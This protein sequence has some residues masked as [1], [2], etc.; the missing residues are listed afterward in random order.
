MRA[1]GVAMVKVK[2]A[3]EEPAARDGYRVL[4]DRL[5]PRGVKK[6][7]LALDDWAKELA[8]S[9]ALRTWFAHDEAKFAEF[10]ERYRAELKSDEA[11]AKLKEL[12]ARAKKQT[13]T[14]VFGARDAEHNNAV[15]LAR[16]L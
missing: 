13:V 6:E 10:A 8:P 14:L 12:R 2:R 16:M 3:Y 4:V 15:V 7:K 1:I 5:W 9:D 11:K